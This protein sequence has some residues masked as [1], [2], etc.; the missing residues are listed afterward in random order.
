MNLPFLKQSSPEKQFFLSLLVKP[1]KVGAILFEEVDGKLA[2]L[3]NHEVAVAE[4]ANEVSSEELLKAS[5]EAISF[6][7]KSLPEGASVDK[8]IFSLPYDWI[9]N[10]KIKPEH[11]DR[12]KTV[13]QSLELVPIGYLTSI[14]AIIHSLEVKEG[15]PVSAIFIEVTNSYIFEYLVLAGKILETGKEEISESIVEACE[16]LFKKMESNSL[17][18]KIIL[19]N[20]VGAE[21]Q[22]QELLSHRWSQGIPFM[23]VPQVVNLESGFENEAVVNG[24][25]KQMELEVSLNGAEVKNAEDMQNN[26]VKEIEPEEQKASLTEAS[27]EEFGFAKEGAASA[28]QGGAT[29]EPEKVKQKDEADIATEGAASAPQGGATDEPEEEPNVKYFKND[30]GPVDLDNNRTSLSVGGILSSAKNFRIPH[31]PAL[32]IVGVGSKNKLI[33]GAVVVVIFILALSFLYYYFILGVNITIFADKKAV[34]KTANVTFSKNATDDHSIKLEIASV[35]VKGDDTKNSTGTKETGD[36]AKGSITIY[37]K[38]ED[39]K[40][41]NKGTILVGP[42]NL[43]FEL[44][45]DVNVASTSPFSTSL[46][47][48]S[49][50]VQ[51]AK[52]GKEYN[53]PS[54]SNFTVKGFQ[55]SDFIGK[56]S[57]TT[58]GGT[59]KTTTVVSKKDLDDLL[60]EVSDNLSKAALSKAASSKKSEESIF[61]KILSSEVVDKKYTKKEGDEAGS[62][63]VSATI[64]FNTGKYI[65]RDVQNYIERL[66]KGDVPGTYVLQQGDSKVDITNIQVG[67]DG[68]SVVAVLKINA[69]YTPEI[70]A[71]KLAQAFR[72]KTRSAVEKQIKNITGVTDVFISFRRRIPIFPIILPFNGSNIKV[73]IKN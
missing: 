42:N 57:D 31:L 53:L 13:C 39:K 27:G 40:T 28:P 2:I 64:K 62:V 33:I 69:V 5:D 66:S 30:E 24:V 34:E 6:V 3:A 48:I 51:A 65:A 18:A 45:D 46:S 59:S 67:K 63:G 47:S 19:L 49:G 12:L 10:A 16:K 1:F 36:R 8:T 20:Y 61:P 7:E 29:D 44:Q 56:N 54:N 11:L 17:P 14:E 73:E 55:A 52:F 38:T 25:A 9:T 4:D 70:D 26:E 41:F 35:E 58:S 71:S 32:P 37:N 50:K 21:V 15:A 22:Q 68:D 43:E 72:G 60:S 23:H